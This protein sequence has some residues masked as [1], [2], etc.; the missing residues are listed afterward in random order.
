MTSNEEITLV[1]VV[2]VLIIALAVLG[3]LIDKWLKQVGLAKKHRGDGGWSD[4]SFGDDG[5]GGD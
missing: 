3:R 1:A 4:G 2:S 5:G